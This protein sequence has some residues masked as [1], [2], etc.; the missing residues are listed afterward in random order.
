M[1][2]NQKKSNQRVKVWLRYEVLFDIW[3]NNFFCAF[4]I[5]NNDITQARV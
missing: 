4:E 1:R 3:P 5:I 2:L